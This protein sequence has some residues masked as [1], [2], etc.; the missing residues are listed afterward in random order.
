MYKI[1]IVDDEERIRRTFIRLLEGRGYYTLAASNA[2]EAKDIIVKKNVDLILL[3]I[4][5]GEVDGDIFFEVAHAFHP[6]IKI[7]VS[8]VYPLEEQHELIQG[9][10]DYY[11]KSESLSFLLKKINKALPFRLK[12]PRKKIILV[13][14]DDQKVRVIYHELL[15]NAGYNSLEVTDSDKV[16]DFLQ[17]QIKKI[18][19]IILD[20]AMPKITGIDFFEV[21]KEKYPDTRVIIS[22]NYEVEEQEA[23]VF[24]ADD[25]YDKS[26]G[27]E[28]LLK[29]VAHLIEN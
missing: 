4:N 28:I 7:I 23:L 3:D 5:M 21:I 6:H 1:L 19:L 17:K 11:D 9:A 25:Y 20:L 26:D 14:D 24:T 15:S 29:K 12:K 22:S 18:D 16:F 8:S 10:D 13:I 2:A 27:N